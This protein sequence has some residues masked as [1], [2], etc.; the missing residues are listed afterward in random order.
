MNFHSPG[1]QFSTLL[2]GKMS[3]RQVDTLQ[4]RHSLG[5]KAAV[6]GGQIDATAKDKILGIRKIKIGQDKI[7]ITGD[8]INTATRY[9]SPVKVD[10]DQR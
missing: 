7:K 1:Q 4:S 5:Q 6:D 10:I 2:G 9:Q 3:G 8:Q